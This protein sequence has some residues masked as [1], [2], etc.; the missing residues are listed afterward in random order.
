M[1]DMWKFQ[2]ELRPNQ[3]FLHYTPNSGVFA[4]EEIDSKMLLLSKAEQQ[5]GPDSRKV[6]TAPSWPGASLVTLPITDP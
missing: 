2:A 5:A 1:G 4:F 6:C 3:H